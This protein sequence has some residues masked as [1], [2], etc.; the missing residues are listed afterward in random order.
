MPRHTLINN[1]HSIDR[2]KSHRAAVHPYATK[3]AV[4][5]EIHTR[6]LELKA[7]VLSAENEFRI[8]RG[9]LPSQ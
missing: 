8:G 1:S 7:R 2:I 6:V 3:W 5:L 4:A 9:S